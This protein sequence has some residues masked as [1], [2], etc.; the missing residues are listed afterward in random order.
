MGSLIAQPKVTVNIIPASQAVENTDQQILFVGQKVAAGSA[1]AGVLRLNI[2]ND[3]SENALF[4]AKSMLAG[5]LRAAKRMNQITQMD[6]IA[7]DDNGS[8]VAAAGSVDFTGTATAAGTL[9]VTIGSTFNYKLNVGIAVG[10]TA[11]VIGD[12]LAAAIAAVA[13]LPVTGVNTTGSVAITASNDGTL[14]NDIGLSSAGSVAGVTVA[15]TGMSGGAT[16]PVLTGVF[17]VIADKRYQTIIWPYA[18]DTAEL[19][20]LLDARFNSDNKVLDGVGI[21]SLQDS[22]SNHLS[23]LGALNSQSLTYI[24]D[25]LESETLYKAPAQFELAPIKAAQVGAIRALRLTDGA[26]ISRFVI[27][28]NGPRDSFGGP[29]LAS[30]PYF[31]TTTPDLPLINIGHGWNDSEIEQ[32]HDAGGS[33]LGQN[34]AGNTSIMGEIV[35]TYKTD[36]AAN[37]DV[38]FKYLNYVDT[39]SNAREYFHNNLKA[40]FG[41]SRLTEGDVIRGRDMANALTIIGFCETLYLDLAGPDFVLLQSGEVALQYFKSNLTVDIDLS[42]GRATVGM[43]VPLVTQLRE[44]L[45]TM[46]ISFSTTS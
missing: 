45:A 35:T 41:Q 8:G 43:T 10:D 2:L 27:T 1:T 13:N 11:T 28:T 21:T 15:V 9:V 31:N 22:L 24:T 14:G 34:S 29:A 5:M 19:R 25:K 6:A 23:L 7:L 4:G 38:S 30:K 36:A 26:S 39:A 33:V 20:S 44:I 18:S 46:K 16:D 32:L 12:T 3:N 40:R 17:D 37:P 42:I